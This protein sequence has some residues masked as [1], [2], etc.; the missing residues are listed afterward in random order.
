MIPSVV[1]TQIRR[2][3]E[4][5][6]RTTF[7]PTT[8]GFENLIERFIQK[9]ENVC[10]GP[11][12]S[13][14][15]PFRTG[16]GGDPF[17]EIPLEFTPFLHQEKAFDRLAPPNYR[18][19]LVATGTGSGKTEC[20]LLPV[21][22]HC[23]R[24]RTH[25]ERGIKAIFI[26]PMNALATDQAKRIARTI[27]STPALKGQVTAGLYVGDADDTPTSVMTPDQAITDKTTLLEAPPD[28]LL[29]NYKMLDYLLLRPD[30]QK[31]WRDNG[32]ETLR[33]LVV[34]EFHTFDGAQG[35][36][37]ACL[38]RRLKH[39]L[40]TPAGHVA[41]V[42]TSATLGD[43]GDDRDDI[44]KYARD[45]FQEP[46]DADALVEEDRLTAIEF[47]AAT[48]LN[49]LPLPDESAID[50]LRPETYETPE[51]YIRG[52]VALWLPDLEIPDGEP[53]G[54]WRVRLGRELK[55]L[56]IV[57]NLIHTLGGKSRTY[58]DILDAIGQ[59]LRLPVN[60][61]EY[62]ALLL[63]SLLALVGTARREIRRSDG[64]PLRVPWVT[65]RV[66]VWFRELKRM[67]AS[68][69]P[70][71]ELLY[72]DDLAAG[73]SP[74][75][76]RSRT[77]PVVHCRD[78]GA[79]GW[80][81]VR[82]SQ[83]AR[84]LAGD[85]LRNFYK[86]FFNRS[87]LVTF[88]FPCD[89][90][91]GEVDRELLCDRCL[92]LNLPTAKHC[93]ACNGN[94]LIPVRIPDVVGTE[95]RDGQTRS[96]S[97]RDC[98]FCGNSNG[99]SIV[100]AQAA[101][102]T[103]ATIGV[104]YTT[105]FNSDKKLLTFSD[106]VQDAAHR[107]G[108]YGARTYRT[109]LRTAIY[110]SVRD[111]RGHSDRRALT[112]EELTRQFPDD[113]KAK[114]GTTNYVATFLPTDLEW[115]RDWD[116]FVRSDRGNLPPETTLPRLVDDRLVWEI[117]TQFGLR[118]AIGPSLERSGVCG[119][120][121]DRDRLETAVRAL[122]FQLSNEVEALRT[123]KAETVREF[124]RGFLHHLRQR[125]GI[126]QPVTDG[127]YI[128]SG[129]QTFLWT[130]ISYMPRLGPSV[131]APK[132]VVNAAAKTDRFDRLSNLP[133]RP[134][135][136][137]EDW[138]T[139]AFAKD[140]LL[141][142]DQL[143]DIL[144]TT[145]GT[146]VE[147]GLLEV[148]DC[149]RGRAW[150]I[151]MSAIV[152]Y[153]G[154]RVMA[155]DRCRHQLT[156]PDIPD[157]P[158][159]STCRHLKCRGHYRPDE[160]GG[161][162]YYREI[163]RRGEVRRI[164]AA[165]HTGLLARPNRERLERNFIR[166][167][168]R[169]DPN[170]LSAT[171]T[172][173]M[174]INIGDLSAVVL[175]S[176]PPASAN[177][178]QRV[179]RA[180]RRDGNALVGVVACGKPHDLFFYADPPEMLDGSVDT[181]GCYLNAAAILERQM[182]AFCLDN[183]VATGIST[184]D[185]PARLGDVLNGVQ[186]QDK[187]RFP[188]NWFEFVCQHRD[189]LT[190][191]FLSLF[192]DAIDSGTKERLRTFVEV[193]ENERGGLTWRILDRL[194]QVN[195]ELTRLKSQ[196]KNIS[197]KI[198]SLK[199]Q[200]E[201]LREQ[202]RE[203]IDELE[204]EKLSISSL[205]KSINSKHIF[206]FFTDESFLP[207]YAFPEAGV[208]LR[209][210]ILRR[211]Q[212]GEK[213]GK[214]FK[215]EAI[216]YERPSHLAIRELVPS[217]VF[218]AEGR[219]VTIDQ[220]DLKL[221]EP[222]T[223]R[224]CRNCNYATQTFTPEAEQRTC[225]RCGDSMWDDRG[226]V[227]QML[228]L[229]QVM[230]TTSDRNSRFGD[231]SEDR[232]VS[233]FERHLLVDC[234]PAFREGTFLV[235]DETFPFGFEYISQTTFREINLG[236]SLGTGETVEIGG[237][238]FTTR[239]FRVCRN[240]GKVMKNDQPQHAIAC[241]WRDKPEQ[242]KVLE[243]LY[244]YRE[245]E[246]ESIRFLMPDE[247]FWTPEGLHSFIAAL[248]LGLKRKF[249]GKVDH[250][251]TAV[252]E[253]PQPHRKRRKSFLYLYDSIPGGTGYLKQ[254]IEKP[255]EL[256]DVLEKALRKIRGCNCWRGEED[257]FYRGEEEEEEEQEQEKE[258]ADDFY[259]RGKDGCYRC[260]FAYRNS[261][262]Q[263]RTSRKTAIHL[264]ART[265]AHWPKLR[266]TPDTLSAIRIDST[267]ESELEGNFI[268]ALRNYSGIGDRPVVK[269][270][271]I[272]G[273][274]GYYVKI[275]ETAWTLKTQVSLDSSDGVDVP[276]RADFVFCPASQRVGSKP[277]V[278]FTDGWEYHRDR[279][280][281]DFR[282]RTAILRSG[283]FWCW[284][285]TWD[286]VMRHVKTNHRSSA[287]PPDGINC[288][289][290][291]PFQ[292]GGAQFYTQYQCTEMQPLERSRS[293]E[294]LMRYL[295]EPEAGRWQNW[296]LLR[297]LAQGTPDPGDGYRSDLAGV[298][299]EEA[300]ERWEAPPRL[301]GGKIA[302]S[303]GLTL[304]TA[305]DLGRHK[306]LDPTGS[307]VAIVLD[308]GSASGEK[309]LLGNWQEALR[310]FN[311]YQFLP[312]SY[313]G[314]GAEGEPQLPAVRPSESENDAGER[315]DWKKLGEWVMVD[316]LLPALDR[317]AREGWPI[318]EAGYELAIGGKVAAIGELAWPDARIAVTVTPEDGSAFVKAGWSVWDVADFS[319]SPDA[320]GDLLRG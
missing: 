251:R 10:R 76:R 60:N 281:E 8:P 55:T 297:T 63:D 264:L 158:I 270:E 193:G 127:Q 109:T 182:T 288:S 149:D 313:A 293:F 32:A 37:L 94:N 74:S 115:L 80:A 250:L 20:F 18:S 138:T 156:V 130:R 213:N 99:L 136:W 224:F 311:L 106:S 105:P 118:S 50:L 171:S 79:T 21:L 114:L 23:R 216:S 152:L 71:P 68:V 26:Y 221:S 83:S 292:K 129:G 27:H 96:V 238:K 17:P 209:S 188:Y 22:E 14:G 315:G 133:G 189:G 172:L 117:V 261:F 121:F 240:C 137:Y 266:R 244:L 289:L 184:R 112:L 205:I 5:Y 155:C 306:Q 278:V 31:L 235:D 237:N 157:V 212:S 280:P 93:T 269:P 123:V 318:P 16:T 84:H 3:V 153:P 165:E 103:S 100:G 154:G 274:T 196:I 259:R 87:P 150:G 61:P 320:L 35:T 51:A 225:P 275:G 160:R 48:L 241:Q 290:N 300:V 210:V 145:C 78:C 43:N 159:P 223:W 230:A 314:T 95:N 168:R 273:K 200:P 6:L 308:E 126:L 284:S 59:K 198:K 175:C 177:Y 312:H 85:D 42:G 132:F 64:S 28:I 30:V 272:N 33:Y 267:L 81:G 252:S 70:T 57:H 124:I 176:V 201:A 242:A 143:L 89:R 217:G 56:P 170:L 248:Q 146:L 226:R 295:A 283:Q 233:F 285:V 220:I 45:I 309:E 294:W 268:V 25:K 197:N 236:E 299:S 92:T 211:L 128:S 15:L 140:S 298:V 53:D 12:I 246:S 257:N 65:L 86:A 2:C 148:R 97:S 167:D 222:E 111:F 164:V 191:Q 279:I 239:G 186:R 58:D 41:C 302:V 9:P 72:S 131:P 151:P 174:G 296:A 194:Q 38:V 116:A 36:D 163:Y 54:P 69:K 178:Q 232:N 277:V 125:G 1:A 305:I 228:R 169:C 47:L 88:L 187:A 207:N 113:W 29:T 66:Q 255:D 203:K 192:E 98:P 183:W 19:T 142:K 119:V 7:N 229:R 287:I 91:E 11:Y 310:L 77:L 179:G 24:R 82:P 263:D 49:V 265:L 122:E 245:F 62:C 291:G 195:R 147:S 218:Y 199:N 73:P 214:K 135:S 316:D 166:G 190:E 107:A 253:E 141:L 202:D 4:D 102:L 139:R 304:W 75:D 271:I 161:L 34:D 181:A 234:D 317:M 286:D 262:D 46:F 101:S 256:Q 52:Q 307:L 215:P 204:Y 282:Q 108:F 219:K 276:S 185:F 254:L 227:R 40:G 319:S 134:N 249:K 173:E 208:T 258:E 144:Q 231:D 67:V 180:G 44:L 104:F 243:V 110:Q 260:V 13:L 303:E 39:R 162:A 90:A 301:V 206:N 120:D 247:S